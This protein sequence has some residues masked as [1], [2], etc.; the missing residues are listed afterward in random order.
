MTGTISSE[1]V[2]TKEEKADLEL[3]SLAN[4]KGKFAIQLGFAMSPELQAA[5]ERGIDERWFDFVDLS[6]ISHA[7]RV[8]M[9]IFR[10]TDAGWVR[11][12]Q[13]KGQV[14]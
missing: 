9:R 6:A 2:P 8:V 10:L 13:L 1:K 5:F 7:Q 12:A 4:E 14:L 3:L 11:L